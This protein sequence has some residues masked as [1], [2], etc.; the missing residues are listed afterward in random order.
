VAQFGRPDG[1]I[2]TGGWTPTPIN[3]EIDE[4]TPDD[5]TTEVL[6]QDDP[7]SDQMEVSLSNISDPSVS[8]GHILRFRHQHTTTGG[9]SAP[10][11]TLVGSLYQG[12]TLIAEASVSPS[13]LLWTTEALTLSGSE[14]DSITDYSDLRIRFVANKTG[15]NRTFRIHV[16]WAELETPDSG[17]TQT[18]ITVTGAMTF[19]GDPSPKDTFKG[20][21]GAITFVGLLNRLTS[22]TRTG[23]LTFIGLITK[24]IDVPAR[25]A[26]VLTFT[27]I[28]T[29]TR[30]ILKSVGGAITFVGI[31]TSIKIVLKSV[32]GA[33]TFVGNVTRLTSVTRA[34]ALTFVGLLNRLTDIPGRTA[35]ALTFAGAVLKRT[36]TSRVAGAITFIGTLSS[37]KIV[38]K[39]VGGAITFVGDLVT[40]FIPGGTLFF[41]DVGQGAITFAGGL[42][43]STLKIVTGAL[44]FV[45]DLVRSTLK[46]VS[47]V[48][49]FSSGM[50]KF[51]SK[52]VSGALTF[53]GIPFKRTTKFIGG[54]ISFLGSV[55][56]TLNVG[57][58]PMAVMLGELPV[59]GI[60][61]YLQ[62]DLTAELDKIVT[63]RGDSLPLES[64]TEWFGYER[65]APSPERVEVEV[66]SEEDLTFPEF[67]VLTS[68]YEFATVTHLHS[69]LP[70]K[71]RL[72]HANRDNVSRGKM[73]ER[74]WRYLSALARLFRNDPTVGFNDG[75][76]LVELDA[77]NDQLDVGDQVGI[78]RVTLDMTVLIRE[79]SVGEGIPS[80]GVP[81]TAIIEQV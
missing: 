21:D 43:K 49:T 46:I 71:I 29:T 54:A 60:L 55:T 74:N 67:D 1:D 42:V 65:P 77:G 23:A 3:P 2:S 10:T 81:P 17:G 26:G 22:V 15:G 41:Q 38:L 50:V 33:I 32:G 40:N 31:L 45:G 75:T 58:P 48:L 44:T 78:G 24:L 20:V 9:G 16:T 64:V 12:T 61:S 28:L 69:L 80:G 57:V 27:G 70:V 19:L 66:Y 59:K 30:N 51:I 47:G 34:G 56:P 63:E 13:K 8:T 11:M 7:S 6:S 4:V 36:I 18:D 72:S 39:S 53:V 52:T 5:G 76:V 35:G 37:T 62:S 25:V 14:A 68:Q 73:Q 79:Q